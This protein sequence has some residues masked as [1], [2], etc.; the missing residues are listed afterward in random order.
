MAGRRMNAEW[1]AIAGLADLALAGVGPVDIYMAW[2]RA[3][4][5]ARHGPGGHWPVMV[6]FA[7]PAA[8]V[9][10]DRW[11][12]LAE[13]GEQAPGLR[14][15]FEASL[16]RAPESAI[17]TAMLPTAAEAALLAGVRQGVLRRFQLGARC[18]YEPPQA[19]PRAGSPRPAGPG[20]AVILGVIDDGC[21]FAHEAF[22]GP[23]GC[24]VRA[25]WDQS[26][27]AGPVHGWSLPA[28]AGGGPPYR[29]GV[30]LLGADLDA[31]LAAHPQRGEA[32]ERRLYDRLGRRDW[33]RPS[34]THGARVLHLLAGPGTMAGGLDA[35][36]MPVVFVQLPQQTVGDATGDSLGTHVLD[37][38]RYIVEQARALAGQRQDWRVVINISLGSI[39][40]P[41]DGTSMAEQGLADLAAEH[42][43]TL[44]MAAG[45]TAGDAARIHAQQTLRDKA[46][47]RFVV[48]V[49][50][51]LQRDSFVELW[52]D[53]GPGVAV[54]DYAARVVAP[55]GAAS[56]W[57]GV[58]QATERVA[59]DAGPQAGLFF[60]RHVAQ[61]REDT[62]LLLAVAPT[63]QAP[64]RAGRT[65]APAGFWTVELTC[66]ARRPVTV[67]GWVERDDTVIGARRPQ[68]ARFET[69]THDA[70]DTSVNDDSTLSNLANAP[71][72]RR[73]GGFVQST[74]RVAAYSANG[75]LRTTRPGLPEVEPSDFA[76]SDRSDWLPG[77]RVPGFFSGTHST[78][79]G[80]SAAAPQVARAIA[81]QQE[82]PAGPPRRPPRPA[83]PGRALPPNARW[84][85]LP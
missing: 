16:A 75:P 15:A 45:N 38:A 12:G 69:P 47:G 31:L 84:H 82:E 28:A 70:A 60:P 50:P 19:P 10:L 49:P 51:A 25:L 4:A 7:G 85:R 59:P 21:C 5:Q 20:H 48:R 46:P 63:A 29:Y 2:D 30:E 56:D 83:R 6:E 73:V 26:P 35:G 40:G 32:A 43:V 22:R 58:G 23:G 67:H 72:L 8:A 55:G 74:G 52:L 36:T 61:G 80:T 79:S 17:H 1:R 62:M 71:G 3:T 76:P 34:R 39:A 77:L 78:I 57:I 44:V 37:G 33:G 24:R 54:T 65:L 9:A 14:Q 68:Q 81:E 18:S 41:H 53:T 64:D 27:A 11:A 42:N 66:A 13:V